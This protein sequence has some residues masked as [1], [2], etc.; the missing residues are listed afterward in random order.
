MSENIYNNYETAC[1]MLDA[2]LLD[3]MKSFL[4]KA[5]HYDFYDC[6]E[7]CDAAEDEISILEEH[8]DRLIH[9]LCMFTETEIKFIKKAFGKI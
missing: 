9:L 3:I 5:E 2:A 7:F 4:K 8:D 1:Q 6:E